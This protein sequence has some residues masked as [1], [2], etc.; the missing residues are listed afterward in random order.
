MSKLRY[1]RDSFWTDSYIEKLSP[2]EKL[3]FLYL[4]TNPLNN[5][6]GIYEIRAKRIGFDTGYDMEVVENILERFV[7]DEKI[8]RFNDLIA[9]KNHIKNQSINPSIVKG[10]KRIINELSDKNRQVVT[11][12]GQTGIINLTLLNLTIY[13]EKEISVPDNI[14]KKAWSD[15]VEHRINIKKKLTQKAADIVFK[16]FTGVNNK[17]QQ[18]MVDNCIVGKWVTVFPL[19]KEFTNV[20]RETDYRSQAEKDEKNKADDLKLQEAARNNPQIAKVLREKK[21]I[22]KRA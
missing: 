2:D 3:I 17:D 16:K 1:I 19:K 14:N 13:I 18:Q 15:F 22:L 4:L 8:L 11:D 12:W 7:R 5:V 20:S 21:G 10:C 9:I 6:A